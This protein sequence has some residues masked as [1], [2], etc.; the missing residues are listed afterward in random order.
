[1]SIVE[2]LLRIKRGKNLLSSQPAFDRMDTEEM[3]MRLPTFL[4]CDEGH[5]RGEIGEVLAGLKPGRSSEDEV[6]VFKSVGNAA[7]DLAVANL[8]FA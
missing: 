7:Q 1:M 2:R 8:A 3:H 4:R 5:I 6:T